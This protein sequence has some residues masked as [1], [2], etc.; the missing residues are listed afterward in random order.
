MVLPASSDAGAVFGVAFVLF[1][2]I[3]GIA[4]AVV[5]MQRRGDILQAA[6]R[7]FGGAVVSSFWSGDRVEFSVEGVPAELTY[8]SGSK[9]TPAYTRVRFRFTP[10]GLLRIVPEGFFA[11]LRKAFGAEDIELGDAAF[12]R[13]FLVQGS[14]ASWVREV[15]DEASRGRLLRIAALAAGFWRGPAAS[16]DAGPGGVVIAC[17]RHL[18]GDAGQLDAFLDEAVALFG[19]IRTP[20]SEQIEVLTAEECASRGRCPVCAQPLEAATRRCG[21]CATPH[22]SDCWDYF[23]GCAIYGCARQ[24]GK[25]SRLT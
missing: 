13:A 9:N 8:H 22:H 23:G 7:R 24:G 20:A 15:L 5:S 21:G 10:P 25:S 1:V 14:P 12:D 6:A 3:V 19:Q 4:M 16:V 2:V 18:A 11:S 17:P